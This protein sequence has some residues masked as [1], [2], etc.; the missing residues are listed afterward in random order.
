[1]TTSMGEKAAMKDNIFL[2]TA[3]AIALSIETDTFHNKAMVLSRQIEA[4]EARLVTTQAI[5]LEI[6]NALAKRNLRPAAIKLL[7]SLEADETIVIIPISE[8]LYAKA[9]VLYCSRSDKEWGLTDCI[10]FVVMQEMDLTEALTADRHFEQ[11]GF[12]ALMR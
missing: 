3:F 2:D 7:K 10:S 9:F 8:E 12:K 1:M 6:G 5:L 11:A 4:G